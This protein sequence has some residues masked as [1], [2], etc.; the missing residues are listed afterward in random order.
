MSMRRACNRR[1]L[2]APVRGFATRVPVIKVR[3]SAASL[4]GVLT[5][6]SGVQHKV[7]PRLSVP[8]E[9][10][11]PVYALPGGQ[12]PD[13]G[14]NV[15][16][17]TADTIA[18]IREACSLASRMRAYAGTLVKVCATRSCRFAVVLIPVSQPGVTTDAIDKLVHAE[19][20]RNGAY[21]SPLGYA[22]FPKSICTS[23]N[24]VA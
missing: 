1:V 2:S 21:P 11:R 6:G 5:G 3:N 24:E 7:S 19:I 12:V 20:I 16:I 17:N 10:K 8:A 9:I 15:T 14:E 23:L 4:Q 18:R 13:M 22:G